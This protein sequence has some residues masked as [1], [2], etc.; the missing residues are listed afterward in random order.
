MMSHEVQP[1]DPALDATLSPSTC[2]AARDERG[3]ALVISLIVLVLLSVIALSVLATVSTEANIAGSDLQRARTFYA[4]EA[5]LEKMTNDFNALFLRKPRPTRDD[6]DDIQEGFPT[7][8]SGEGFTAI[9][10]IVRGPG[11]NRYVP[12]PDGPFAG[13][14]AAI[15][16]YSMRTRVTMNTGT[17]VALQREM[18]N[19]L[20]P[21]FQ[22][23]VFGSKDL[24]FWPEPPMTFN[25]RVHANGNIYFGGNVTF[26][27]R[28]TTAAEAVVGN[29]TTGGGTTNTKLR[30]NGTLSYYSNPRFA[31]GTG[32]SRFEVPLTQ[33]SVLNGP[34]LTPQPRAD[35]RGNFSDSPAGTDNSTTTWKNNLISNPVAGTPNRLGSSLLTKSTGASKLELPL[36]LGGKDASELIRRRLLSDVV[37]S[38]LSDSRYHTKATIRVLIDDEGLGMGAANS[39]GIPAGRGV[40]LSTFVPIELGGGNALRLIDNSGNYVGNREWEQG[41]PSLDRAASVVRGIKKYALPSSSIGTSSQSNK[42]SSNTLTGGYNANDTTAITNAGWAD[43]VGG[44]IIPSGAGIRGRILIEVVPASTAAVPN[45]A[46]I[47]VTREILSMGMTTGEPNAIFQLQRPAWAAF[48]QGGRDRIGDGTHHNFIN[49]FLEDGSN[50]ADIQNRRC[51]ADGEISITALPNT[52]DLYL[53]VA[54]N[55]L[56]DDT[57]LAASPFV[58][59][60]GNWGRDD[61]PATSGPNEIV[62]INVYNPREGRIAE[63]NGLASNRIYTRGI[64]SVI[65]INMRNLARWVDGVYN[66]TLLNGTS[67]VST[68]IG[69][70]DGYVVYISDRRGDRVKSERDSH[71]DKVTGNLVLE[72]GAYLTTN[73]TVD[74]ENIYDW[75]STTLNPG[76]DVI[77][78]GYDTATASPKKGRLQVDT[79]ELPSPVAAPTPSSAPSEGYLRW[80]ANYVNDWG[81]TIPNTILPGQSQY[82]FRRAVRLMNGEDLQ[83]STNANKLSTTKG[84]TIA[85]EN[86][87]YIW[88]NY[89]TTGINAAP[90]SGSSLNDAAAASRYTG[91]QVPTSLVAD[92]FFPLSKTWY[93][94]QPAMYPQGANS[95]LADAGFT[96]EYDAIAV[97]QETAVRAGIIAGSTL[98]ALNDSPPSGYASSSTYYLAWLNG[99]VHNYPRFLETWS[100]TIS[101][102]K[103]EK[104]WNYVG[105]FIYLYNSMQAVGPWS[106]A[107]SVVYYPPIRNWAFDITFTDPDRLPPGTPLFQYVQATGFRQV[108]AE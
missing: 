49:Y 75:T 30:N 99:G 20:I 108:L 55:L 106:V 43:K 44:T 31:F 11:A 41:K 1:R 67:A 38:P 61:V 6:L 90:T 59:S 32:A 77:D 71:I 21:I 81:M 42:F 27:S 76:E 15:I 72:G 53:N 8:L 94:A 105:S 88:G 102:A 95:R 19:Y 92:A 47:D 25:G 9:Q 87:A 98:S 22:F 70:A 83:I 5:G 2:A 17:Q 13:L 50:S 96:N 35:K 69:D 74:N 64:T 73:G 28:V 52:R 7:E 82:H 10:T 26:E 84:I 60:S 65:D 3:A 89:N 79:N 18:N 93:D 57:H 33:G 4:A 91:D 29:G 63:F 16:P 97:G 107:S 48:M 78:A 100:T 12:V 39:A 23:G 54:D 66:T 36:E 62:P 14:Q 103:K 37:G 56:D 86:M 46:G 40:L 101:G 68:N 34:K 45:P 24:E 51:L 104:R 85:T 80:H 58:P